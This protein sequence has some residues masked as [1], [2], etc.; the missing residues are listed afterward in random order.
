MAAQEIQKH[1][2]DLSEKA[3]DLGHRITETLKR[4]DKSIALSN[5]CSYISGELRQ[6]SNFYPDNTSGLAWVTRNLFET[7]LTIRH[8]LT[9]DSNFSEWLGQALCD[10]KDFIDGVLSVPTDTRNNAAETQLRER[11]AKLQDMAQRHGLE[12]SKPFRVSDIAKPLGL[13]D[14]YNSLYKLFSKYVHPSS[15]LVNSWHQQTPDFNWTNIFLTKSQLYSG[16]SIYR[17]S[18][19]CGF[20]SSAP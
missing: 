16:D 9:S 4:S 10:E 14:E 17:I 3:T 11:L 2:L 5:F 12:F 7:N 15:L 1:L 13:L 8:V 20:Q 18:S 6:A 19:S